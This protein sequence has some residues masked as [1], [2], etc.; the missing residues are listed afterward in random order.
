MWRVVSVEDAAES[1][2]TAASCAAALSDANRAQDLLK[3]ADSLL[4]D[5][6]T[7]S[8]SSAS[9]REEA[10]AAW[11]AAFGSHKD[12]AVREKLAK[13]AAALRQLDLDRADAAARDRAAQAAVTEK[14]RA[15]NRRRGRRP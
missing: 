6:P 12:P 11:D 5:G 8:G 13:A 2:R 14:N 4:A 9:S 7:A 15:R 1:A 3:L 10:I